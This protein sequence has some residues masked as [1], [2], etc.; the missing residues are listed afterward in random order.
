MSCST[1][2]SLCVFH[3]GQFSHGDLIFLF[4]RL[5]SFIVCVCVPLELS[6]PVV[7]IAPPPPPPRLLLTKL[8]ML[9]KSF[10]Y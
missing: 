9:A 1:V 2:Y 7:G 10:S 6:G 5:A 3:G 8:M 4:F